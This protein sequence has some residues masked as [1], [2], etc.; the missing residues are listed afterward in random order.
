M[1]STAQHEQDQNQSA[2]EP[3]HQA[4]FA[5]LVLSTHGQHG[6]IAEAAHLFQL[7]AE[8]QQHATHETCII[9]NALLQIGYLQNGELLANTEQT[10]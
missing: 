4:G 2:L 3:A 9:T 6:L 8:L 1:N 5:L 10:A 7:R